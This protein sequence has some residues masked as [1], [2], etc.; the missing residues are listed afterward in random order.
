[1]M[2]EMPDPEGEIMGQLVHRWL[3]ER[4]LHGASAGELTRLAKQLAEAT[5]EKSDSNVV[6]ADFQAFVEQHGWT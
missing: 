6:W 3:H 1:M 4:R 5:D 2:R